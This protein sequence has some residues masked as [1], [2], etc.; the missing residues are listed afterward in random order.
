MNKLGPAF[1][2]FP[3]SLH[4]LLETRC[5]GKEGVVIGLCNTEVNILGTEE[6]ITVADV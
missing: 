2:L 4:C 5:K 6:V 3:F 1:Q